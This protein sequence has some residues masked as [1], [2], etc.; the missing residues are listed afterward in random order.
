MTKSDD[1]GLS[2]LDRRLLAMLRE[3]SRQPVT[4]L[5]S[6]LGLSRANVYARLSR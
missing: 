1:R 6:D 2:D 3:D 5:A 4:K